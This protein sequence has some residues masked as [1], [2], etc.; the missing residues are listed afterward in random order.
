MTDNPKRGRPSDDCTIRMTLLVTPDEAQAIQ[1]LRGAVP[2]S[3]WL[4]A[5]IR[6]ELAD[7]TS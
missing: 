4:R 7:A 1:R 3:A 5:V 6:R 2:L